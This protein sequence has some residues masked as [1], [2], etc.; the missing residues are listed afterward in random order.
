L[1]WLASS[2]PRSVKKNSSANMEYKDPRKSMCQA[3]ANDCKKL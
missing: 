1:L 2:N 3:E